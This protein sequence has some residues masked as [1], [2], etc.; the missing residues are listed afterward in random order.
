MDVFDLVVVLVGSCSD[1]NTSDKNVSKFSG[2]PLRSDGGN[3]SLK[4][5]RFLDIEACVPLTVLR[6]EVDWRAGCGEHGKL[7]SERLPIAWQIGLCFQPMLKL[8]FGGTFYDCFYG[9]VFTT[10]FTKPMSDCQSFHILPQVGYHSHSAFYHVHPKSTK[11]HQAQL[12]RPDPCDGQLAQAG[13]GCSVQEDT[14]VPSREQAFE[15]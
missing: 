10:V 5:D 11:R 6:S 13:S 7:P 15:A 4:V 3:K 1:L 8:K 14:T 2:V 12:R 9:S